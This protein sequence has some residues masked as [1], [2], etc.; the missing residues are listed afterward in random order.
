MEVWGEEWGEC[1]MSWRRN[2]GITV[3]RNIWTF[4]LDLQT[5]GH[6]GMDAGLDHRSALLC[7]AL[8][9]FVSGVGPCMFT[10]I[11]VLAFRG[12]DA[13]SDEFNKAMLFLLQFRV[14]PSVHCCLEILMKRESLVENASHE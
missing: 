12:F 1:A 10:C 13:V 8:R 14:M 3:G 2:V 5:D 9:C 7:I 11:V 6:S 4:G